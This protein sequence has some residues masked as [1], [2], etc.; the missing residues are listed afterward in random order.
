MLHHYP[1]SNSCSSGSDIVG[2]SWHPYLQLWA[3]ALA[4]DSICFYN[5][6]R[7][8]WD[9]VVLRHQF[10]TK[11]SRSPNTCAY[12][13]LTGNMI[14][15]GSSSGVCLWHLTASAAGSSV[16]LIANSYSD[17]SH[18]HNNQGGG[19]KSSSCQSFTLAGAWMRHLT[20]PGDG[21]TLALAFS[22]CGRYLAVCVEPLST[23]F[24]SSTSIVIW[25]LSLGTVGSTPLR[26]LGSA[27]INQRALL[28]WSPNGQ[29]LLTS[30]RQR[31]F[32]I[33]RTSDWTKTQWKSNRP[34]NA[35]AWN[36]SGSK[37]LVVKQRSCEVNLIS[38]Q[39]IADVLADEVILSVRPVLGEVEITGT[40]QAEWIESLRLEEWER[41]VGGYVNEMVW[42]PSGER[43][44]VSFTAEE[45]LQATSTVSASASLSSAA[46][47]LS[48]TS[49]S[50]DSDL[51]VVFGTHPNMSEHFHLV[52][53]IRG[54][55][56]TSPFTRNPP[57][58]MVS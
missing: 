22:P 27:G 21:R 53:C 46:S 30:T 39:S 38:L 45:F 17:V 33:W 8:E 48:S 29:F 58:H 13:P 37:V 34:L 15:V 1:S 32:V 19:L 44:V 3:V 52:G 42:S 5:I 7:G 50:S 35:A 55:P 26:V 25:D 49:S 4:D 14:A 10:Q 36:A 6:M 43:V 16:N 31:G 41:T 20:R 11:L 40:A 54:P 47:A 56:A 9:A 23:L 2:F 51:L 18:A 28:Q 24:Q 12:N 57:V